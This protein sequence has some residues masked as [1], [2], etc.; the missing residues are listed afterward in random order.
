MNNSGQTSLA[1]AAAP[2]E[3]AELRETINAFESTWPGTVWPPV[4]TKRLID[5][6]AARPNF[7]DTAEWL[8]R[9]NPYCRPIDRESTQRFDFTQTV[10][11]T[12]ALGASALAAHRM[13][14]NIYETDLV[15]LPE[16]NFAARK[17]DFA[18]YYSNDNKLL[19][20]MI[21]PTLEAHVFQFLENEIN[22]T[23]KWTLEAVK[24]YLQDLIVKHEQSELEMCT[25]I[26]SSADPVRAGRALLLQLAC[27]FL[28]EASASA[29]NIL[30]KYGAI[31]SEFFKI[32]IDDYG[33][34]VHPAKH[35]TL[36]E[37][38]L[39][40]A[41]LISEVHAYWKFYLT[42]SLTLSNYYH[43]VCRD[44]SKYFRAIGA[45]AVA[46][47]MFSHTC[48]KVSQ[49][50]RTVFGKSVDTYYFDEHF[51][52]DA[53]H[54]RMAFEHVVAP[55]IEQHG[56]GVIPD[57][58]RGMEE[59]QLLTAIAD[60]DFIA[61]VK[62]LDALPELKSTAQAIHARILEGSLQPSAITHLGTQ[63]QPFI[64]RVNNQDQLYAVQSGTLDLVIGPDE[65]IRLERGDVMIVPRQR[66]H[67]TAV[68]SDECCYR[69]FDFEDYRSCL[70]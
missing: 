38:T 42:S 43:Y 63:S 67:G 3:T 32:V 19:G 64:T 46:E 33:Y 60:E 34:G 53:H 10:N 49:M 24:S 22:V 11:R 20:E 2:D 30:G 65:T 61:Q 41:D 56:N 51:H 17:N 9:D 62:F 68:V 25:A 12:E 50:L 29:R 55:A 36:Y 66:L 28:S 40:T 15:F 58:I 31:Q 37:N 23:G 52:I 45:I 39:A 5:L 48:R 26:V 47:S 70:S 54:G 1:I 18:S 16:K 14:L 7:D 21:R 57:I 69:V 13:L 8:I 4:E 6:Y 35:S 27:D 59:L 44:H